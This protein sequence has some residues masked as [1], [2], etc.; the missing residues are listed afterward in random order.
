M[1]TGGPTEYTGTDMKSAHCKFAIGQ[2]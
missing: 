2:F 1:V